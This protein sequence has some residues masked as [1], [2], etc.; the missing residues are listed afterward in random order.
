MGLR[1]LSSAERTSVILGAGR[2]PTSRRIHAGR[3]PSTAMIR[4]K[5]IYE[6]AR[7]DDGLRIL[8]D[9]LWPRG[10][11]KEKARIDS[12][13]RDIA[14]SDRLRQWFAHDPTKWAAFQRKYRKEL[15]DKKQLI[16]QIKEREKQS[17]TV[18]LLYAAKDDRH[19]NAVALRLLLRA[20]RYP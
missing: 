3:S 15:E 4:V 5:R 1:Q 2:N 12:W 6:P 19:N 10:L 16:R 8:V 17:R 11:S 7:K 9:R 13:L 14:P 20:V 18:T